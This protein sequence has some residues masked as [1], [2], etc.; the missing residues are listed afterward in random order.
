MATTINITVQNTPVTAAVT[1]TVPAVAVGVSLARDAY[2]LALAEGFSGTREEWLESLIGPAGATGASAYQTAVA[3][4]FSGTR[5]EWLESLI[6]EPGSDASVTLANV[7]AALAT[8]KAS[9]PG[10]GLIAAVGANDLMTRSLV[11]QFLMDS[12]VVYISDDFHGGG[13]IGTGVVSTQGQLPWLVT[14]LQGT[15]ALRYG[16]NVTLAVP[17]PGGAAIQTGTNNRDGGAMSWS[18]T[19]AGGGAQ[20]PTDFN[21]TT[22]FKWRFYVQSQM[23]L[24]IGIG[25]NPAAP[26][27]QASRFIGLAAHPAA[28]AWTAATAVAAGDYRRPTT[29]NGLR[30]YASTAGTTHATTEPLWPTGAASTVA[31]G[32]VVWTED[33]R[34]G[35]ANFQYIIRDG[36]ALTGTQTDS[37]VAYSAG[38]HTFTLCYLGGNAWGMSIDGGAEATLTLSIAATVSVVMWGQAYT[39]GQKY[40][41][42]DFFRMFQRGR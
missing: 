39:T 37:G 42:F 24:R 9:A 1:T 20:Q 40:L 22:I 28:A 12:D 26:T 5:E 11:E 41:M 21:S 2:Q 35:S 6:G 36:T 14:T 8:G 3:A 17:C 31:D 15:T 34:D 23:G 16:A 18:V 4:G 32:T 13:S 29:P 7:N 19:F 27:F 30:Y 25:V 10:Q 33:G 38:W